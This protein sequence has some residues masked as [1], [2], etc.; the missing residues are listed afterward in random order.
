MKDKEYPQYSGKVILL[1]DERSVSQS[2]TTIMSLRQ[3]P[4][5][6]V[7]GSESRGANGDLV[8]V[9]LPGDLRINMSGLGVYTAEGEQTQRVGLKPDIEIFPTI[10]GIKEGRDELLE[11]GIEEIL[12]N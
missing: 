9:K 4:N 7:I 10:Q 11:K 12:N 3:S 8:E 6:V 5:A 2:E 1:M